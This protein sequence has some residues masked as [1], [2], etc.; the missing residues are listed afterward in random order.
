MFE[1]VFP[2]V[3]KLRNETRQGLN[4]NSFPWQ[5]ELYLTIELFHPLDQLGSNISKQ[6]HAC[7]KHYSHKN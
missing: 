5:P 2:N 6:R 1:L 4:P 3:W 7:I